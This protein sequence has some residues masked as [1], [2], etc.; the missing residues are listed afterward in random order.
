MLKRAFLIFSALFFVFAVNANAENIKADLKY[1]PMTAELSCPCS[2]ANVDIPVFKLGLEGNVYRGIKL[3]LHYEGNLGKGDGNFDASRITP[4]SNTSITDVSYSNFE[5]AAKFPLDGRKWAAD[6]TPA[7]R[8]DNFYAALCYKN[9]SLKADLHPIGFVNY[10]RDL[11]KANGIGFGLGY[12]GYFSDR[13]GF[14]AEL[15]YYPSMNSSAEAPMDNSF[16]NWVYRLGLKYDFNQ[17]Y[18]VT[19]G[20]EGESHN[21]DGGDSADYK[22][23]VFGLQAR[24]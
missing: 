18:S 19:L 13:F 24:W 4:L 6:Y 7:P 10:S 14:N 12:E 23:V 15:S 20:Y 2:K 16:R 3:G 8:E 9:I 17:Q 11:E 21:Y 5:I 22:G 1:S